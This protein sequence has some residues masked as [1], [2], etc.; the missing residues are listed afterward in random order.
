VDDIFELV[1]A[2]ARWSKMGGLFSQ[3]TLWYGMMCRT[4]LLLGRILRSTAQ[5]LSSLAPCDAQ[6][7]A[8]KR[9]QGK[10]ID[11][12]TFGQ[13]LAVVE[14]LVPVV[15]Q[16]V[17]AVRPELAVEELLSQADLKL[18]KRSVFLRNRMA[19]QG[20]GFLDTVDLQAGRIWRCSDEREP[21][22][23]QAEEIWQISRTLC[24]SPLIVSYLALRGIAPDVSR[25]ELLKIENSVL[26][27]QL[28]TFDEVKNISRRGT[29]SINE[30]HSPSRG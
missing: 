17:Y 28:Q 5:E 16:R 25:A 30:F 14:M 1:S 27:V 24:A 8:S 11:R 29:V 20:P 21:L 10:S 15:S 9:A 26:Q 23:V 12:M 3:G 2:T 13:C 4:F 19:H 18:W 7:I 22:D 6:T